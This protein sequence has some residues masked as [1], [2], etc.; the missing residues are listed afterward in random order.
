MEGHVFPKEGPHPVSGN[1]AAS[2]TDVDGRMRRKL[3]GEYARE[4]GPDVPVLGV[5]GVDREGDGRGMLLQL[6]DHLLGDLFRH[7]HIGRSSDPAHSLDVEPVGQGIEKGGQ[8]EPVGMAH[9]GQISGI[10]HD[11]LGVGDPQP[12]QNFPEILAHGPEEV[13]ELAHRK[14]II[15]GNESLEAM[16]SGLLFV[17]DLGGDPHMAGISLA[18]PADGASDRHHRKGRKSHPVGAEAHELDHVHGG[19]ESSVPPDLHLVPEPGRKER[20]MDLGDSDLH[21]KADMLEGM[22][23]CRPRSPV[24]A[25]DGDDVGPGLG[26]SN[27]D[28]A[29]PRDD[30]DLH[31][32]SGARVGAFEFR[33]K[34]GEILDRIEVVIV[35]GRDEV[36]ARIGATGSGN[37]LGDLASGQMAALSWL[38]AL[39][40][41]D[42]KE[43]GGIEEADIDPETARGDLLATALGIFAD[44]VPDFAALS[45]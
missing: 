30:R 45:V 42:L 28:R 8:V 40:D 22:K 21:G 29:D 44:H 34:L 38:C 32:D 35:R 14:F 33:H 6:P 4:M 26:D 5:D 1:G 15:P 17:L 16:F 24:V 7:R 20:A 9:L 41:L 18:F 11:G 3:P 43:P 31:D 23:P 27:A 10:A 2:E 25:A 13:N 12:R 36:D 39:S 19:L 37:F